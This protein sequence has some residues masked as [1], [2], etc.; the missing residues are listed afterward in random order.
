MPRRTGTNTRCEKKWRGWSASIRIC[1]LTGAIRSQPSRIGRQ[2]PGFAL[3]KERLSL[4][5]DHEGHLVGKSV[6]FYH[7]QYR[8]R[9]ESL[10]IFFWRGRALVSRHDRL[11]FPARPDR[12]AF[13][14]RPDRPG[15]P[16]LLGVQQRQQSSRRHHRLYPVLFGP[17]MARLPTVCG[18]LSLAYPCS[19][20]AIMMAS[21]WTG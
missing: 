1:P 15:I 21:N 13:P 11:A 3:A 7:K 8:A 19:V 18:R 10:R 20:F 12:L 4:V 5:Q 17:R 14:V 16:R 9:K 6:S 2:G